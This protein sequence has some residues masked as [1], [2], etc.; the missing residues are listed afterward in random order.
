MRRRWTVGEGSLRWRGRVR[1]SDWTLEGG[2]QLGRA[3]Q[4]GGPASADFRLGMTVPPPPNH[5]IVLVPFGREELRQEC[6]NV[7]INVFHHEQGFPLEA[8][9]DKLRS[10]WPAAAI[11]LLWVML[12][13]APS[14]HRLDET[15]EHFLL[16]L[17]PSLQPIGTVRA[18]R[19]SCGGALYYK[20]SR[21]AVLKEFRKH[22]FGRELV[23]ALHKWAATDAQSRG[24]HSAKVICHSQIPVKA[25]YAK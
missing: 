13:S 7:R 4:V 14:S 10:I 17:L 21:L 1:P 25:F 20:L 2:A 9:I 12:I 23:L 6:Y 16:R 3:G 22:H 19:A 8:E 5:E 24:E 11:P 15:A 18:S